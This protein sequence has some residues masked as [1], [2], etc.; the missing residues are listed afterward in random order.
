MRQELDVREKNV[1]KLIKEVM[2]QENKKETKFQIT[3][4]SLFLIFFFTWEPIS[5]YWLFAA[6]EYSET[7][8]IILTAFIS[9]IFLA[10]F[11]LIQYVNNT[12]ADCNSWKII[13]KVRERFFRAYY[14]INYFKIHSKFSQ[15]EIFDRIFNSGI[16]I[17]EYVMNY[18]G[19]IIFIFLGAGY[20]YYYWIKTPIVLCFIF[21][22]VIAELY[23]TKRIAKKMNKIEEVKRTA[24]GV[25]AEAGEK[26]L[27]DLE[28]SLMYEVEEEILKQYIDILNKSWTYQRKKELLSEG[29]QSIHSFIQLCL[30]IVLEKAMLISRAKGNL[31][32]AD[33]PI[34]FIVLDK[35]TT[36]LKE[37]V[38]RLLEIGQK[39][40]AVKRILELESETSTLN[41]S[42]LEVTKSEIVSA[43]NL[44][45][46]LDG[47]SI[48]KDIS[49]KIYQG[50]KVAVI[51]NNGCGKSTLLKAILGLIPIKKGS[52][53]LKNR[54][55]EYFTNNDK[56][57]IA[58]IP[59]E[60]FL[61]SESIQNNLE[62]GT[63]E[64]VV[65]IE[66]K[67]GYFCQE[68]KDKPVETLSGGQQ[69]MV[70]ICRGIVRSSNILFADEPTSHL[71][72]DKAEEVMK[73]VLDSSDTCLIITHDMS[74]LP[75]FTR[76]LKIEGGQIC[77]V[78][79]K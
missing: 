32:T 79:I 39:E 18:L 30:Q 16:G 23:I 61:F 72:K 54:L 33:T 40:I 24:E 49:F 47:V 68:F 36:V 35:L 25:K 70:N 6:I 2:L 78:Q 3:V 58:Y 53:F 62:M 17:L 59:V 9:G 41:K 38:Q 63:E 75:L 57:D 22:L 29:I 26:L 45:I 13:T 12:Y 4:F 37:I 27:Q 19:I 10:F 66:K 60:P 67:T 51:G 76:I 21:V 34:M 50:E 28:F 55:P 52:C 71:Q 8:R 5:L 74:L 1:S 46:E 44:S 11:I 64:I 20:S 77:E 7:D 48:L 69:Q 65:D 31:N 73:W 42:E 56:N 14:G 15:G 43:E